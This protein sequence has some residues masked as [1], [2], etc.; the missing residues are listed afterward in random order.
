MEQFVKDIYKTFSEMLSEEEFTN[1]FNSLG[2]SLQK[3][4]GRASLMYQ[5]AIR[6]KSC[7]SDVCIALLCSAVEAVAGGKIVIFKDWLLSKKTSKLTNKGEAQISQSINR[8][9]EE[10]LQS[11]EEREGIAYNF[12][13]FLI[14]YCPDKL[15]NPPI[16]VYKG[17]G[18]RFDIAVRGLYSRFRSFFLHEGVGY[19]SIADKPY[20]DEETGEAVHMTAIPLLTKVDEK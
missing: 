2:K 7:D 6:C 17:K 1:M 20:I 15:K 3:D 12:R 8:A 5:R 16:Q 14:T 11:E 19:A 4:F 18:E 10:Y 9:F 13:N